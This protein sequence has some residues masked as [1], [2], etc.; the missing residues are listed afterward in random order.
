[1]GRINIDEFKYSRLEPLLEKTTI[2]AMQTII[3]E[4][5]QMGLLSE[6]S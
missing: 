5:D 2:L 3:E 1:V 6:R 4:I